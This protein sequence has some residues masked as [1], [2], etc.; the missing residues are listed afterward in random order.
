[1][2]W[3]RD[4]MLLIHCLT[5]LIWSDSVKGS[6]AKLLRKRFAIET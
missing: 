6:C 3:K 4:V 5:P 2:I 1:M